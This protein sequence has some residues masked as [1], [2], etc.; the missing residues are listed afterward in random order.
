MNDRSL[1]SLGNGTQLLIEMI[2]S[3]NINKHMGFL[4]VV[5]F[6]HSLDNALEISTLFNED[7]ND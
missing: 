7:K 1:L 2:S 6:H 5:D 3:L 4:K